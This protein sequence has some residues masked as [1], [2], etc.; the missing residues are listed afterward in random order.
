MDQLIL[1]MTVNNS[2]Y[3][4][5]NGNYEKNNHVHCYRILSKKMWLFLDYRKCQALP[6]YPHQEMWLLLDYRKCYALLSKIRYLP[7][8]RIEDD[9]Y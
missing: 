5:I 7:R 3:Y 8:T 2:S 1:L 6:S 4:Y 9:K